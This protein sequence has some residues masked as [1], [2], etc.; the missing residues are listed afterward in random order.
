[1]AA[2]HTPDVIVVVL[3]EGSGEITPNQV[4]RRHGLSNDTACRWKRKYGGVDC[5][6]ELQGPRALEDENLGL[7]RIVANMALKRECPTTRLAKRASS[8]YL[9]QKPGPYAA[10]R[11]DRFVNASVCTP[12]YCGTGRRMRRNR[13]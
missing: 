2:H 3:K 4:I 10:S 11:I 7:K 12:E 8:R 5:R 1:M 6:P 9:S 13:C